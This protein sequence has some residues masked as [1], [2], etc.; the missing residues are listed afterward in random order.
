MDR[1]GTLYLA[2]I[3]CCESFFLASACTTIVVGKE[4]SADG[5]TICTHNADVREGGH[6]HSFLTNEAV[7]NTST[8]RQRTRSLYGVSMYRSLQRWRTIGKVGPNGNSKFK[9]INFKTFPGILIF[10][11][12]SSVFCRR[13][14]ACPHPP[15]HFLACLVFLLYVCDCLMVTISVVLATSGWDAYLPVTGLPVRSDPLSNTAQSI[16]AQVTDRVG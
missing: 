3:I 5:S 1:V 12:P 15:W 10:R 7:Y 13:S 14:N 8:G 6:L 2:A 9:K 11:G 16:P 4:A